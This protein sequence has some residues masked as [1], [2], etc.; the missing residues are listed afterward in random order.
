MS[1]EQNQLQRKPLKL[2]V[3]N[4]LPKNWTAEKAVAQMDKLSK[5]SC[6]VEKAMRALGLRSKDGLV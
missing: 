1:K 2:F 6:S 5:H 4:K 3:G